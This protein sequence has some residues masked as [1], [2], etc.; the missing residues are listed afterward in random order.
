MG[1]IAGFISGT[2]IRRGARVTVFWGGLM[3][4][5]CFNELAVPRT[6]FRFARD[7]FVALDFAFF[8][9]WRECGAMCLG[10]P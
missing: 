3:R 10:L 4:F 7:F 8:T 6:L 9:V 5:L 1:V 2:A